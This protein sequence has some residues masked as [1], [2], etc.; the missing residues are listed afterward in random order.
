MLADRPEDTFGV[1]RDLL[2]TLENRLQIVQPDVERRQALAAA[3]P[4]IWPARGWMNDGYGSRRDPFDGSADYHPGL[5]IS[6]DRGD[7]CRRR[8]AVLQ[9]PGQSLVAYRIRQDRGGRLRTV[10]APTRRYGK[11]EW[12]INS[13]L[14]GAERVPVTISSVWERPFCRLLHFERAFSIRRAGRSRTS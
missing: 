1:L 5:D 13:T 6:A 4:S 3:T 2:Y 8:Q 9:E 12:K 14:I 11:P 7:L 10:R